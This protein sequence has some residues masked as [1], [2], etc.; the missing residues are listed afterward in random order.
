M[1]E[2]TSHIV[3]TPAEVTRTILFLW[4]ASV[5]ITIITFLIIF[6]KINPNAETTYAL[7]YN[8]VVGVDLLGKGSD[9]YKI[10]LIGGS[11][12]L[13]NYAIYRTLRAPSNVLSF[14]LALASVLITVTLLLATLFLLKVN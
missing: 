14:F 2:I 10:P 13:V 3:A 12:T 8:V 7:H 1:T 11:I 5:V 9:F 6:F 4:I